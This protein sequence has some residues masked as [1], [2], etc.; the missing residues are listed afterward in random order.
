MKAY[1]SLF[2]SAYLLV[3]GCATIVPG[4]TRADARLKADIVKGIGMYELA[5]GG[6]HRPR[7]HRTERLSDD[8]EGL[9]ELWVVDRNGLKIPYVVTLIP[10]GEGGTFIKIGRK[11]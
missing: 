8:S 10:D 4:D 3:A 2:M 11:D 9:H 6:S 5:A 1:K 7:I